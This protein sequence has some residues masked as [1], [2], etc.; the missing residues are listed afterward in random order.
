MLKTFDYYII[1]KFLGTFFYA[2][3]LIILIVIIFDLSE[4]IDD[5]I[6]KRAPLNEILFTYYINFIPYFINLFSP[7]FTFVA[8][9]FF[10][11]RLAFNTEIIA[12]LSAG[13]SFRRLLLPYLISSVFL[14]LISVYLSNFMIPS[15]NKKRINFE[16]TYIKNP[17]SFRDRNIHMQIRPGV[18][19]YMESFNT[20]THT[21]TR[22]ALEMIE[23]GEL[24]YK[25]QADNASWD[26]LSGNWSIDRY[27]IRTIDGQHETLTFGE[28]LDTLLPFSPKD[29]IQNLAEM[30]TMKF[31]ELREFIENEKLK[32]SENVKFYEV[33]K[34]RR[35]S[36]PFATLVLTLIGVSLSSRK[37]RGGIGLHLGI[38]LAI[39]FSYILFLQVS[40][41]FA[42]N[43]NLHPF[44]S[45]WIP[46]IIFTLVGI[47]LLKSAPK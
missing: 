14:A 19:V 30:E 41:T 13:V 15:A 4:K 32:G 40:T 21:G 18:F 33:E 37:V 12:I 26:S 10:T 43:G 9:I 16:Y 24:T 8:V 28:K 39:S 3:T 20:W 46:N 29:F 1:R 25:L 47:Y 38:G 31:G 35:M 2:I 36:F 5:F 44:L 11:S 22:F 34:H 17:Q 27:H 23:D 45:V 6:E 42:T 7:L